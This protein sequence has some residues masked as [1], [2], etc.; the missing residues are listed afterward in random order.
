[1]AFPDPLGRAPLSLL[2]LHVDGRVDPGWFD[3]RKV[4]GASMEMLERYWRAVVDVVPDAE[5]DGPTGKWVRH[6]E[7][8]RL[9]DL[10]GSVDAIGDVMAEFVAQLQQAS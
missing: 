3:V 8:L 4:P 5:F 2:L 1:M 10:A 7:R 6:G 9:A